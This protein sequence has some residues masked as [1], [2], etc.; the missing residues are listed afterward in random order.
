[1]RSTTIFKEKPAV[2]HIM[3]I[4]IVLVLLVLVAWAHIASAQNSD[5]SFE[6]RC[7]TCHTAGNAVGAPLPETLRQMSWQAIL[8]ALETGKMKPVGDNLSATEREAIA[9]SL[10]TAESNPMPPS[11]KCSAAPQRAPATGNW[12]GWA[13]AAN[14][15]FQTA[16]QEIGR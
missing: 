3:R 12:N 7:A 9:K 11:A 6:T 16:R 1:M 4:R 14:T 2:S 5:A 13:D 15:R 10:G 8:A